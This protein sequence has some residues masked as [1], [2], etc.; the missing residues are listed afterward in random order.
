MSTDVTVNTE[1]PNN[2][3]MESNFNDN[4][5]EVMSTGDT[6][7]SALED[8]L[9]YIFITEKAIN[10]YKNQIYLSYVTTEK[11]SMKI[12]HKKIQNYIQLKRDKNNLLDIMRRFIL[13]RGLICI[14]CEDSSLFIEFQNLYVKYFSNN[15]NLRIV[16]SNIKLQDILDKNEI[17]TLIKE[18][19]MTKNHRGINEV[20]IEI[21]KKYF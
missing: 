19:H 8:S 20:Y 10:L 9:D 17:I 18:E 1:I 3:A 12:V 13:D 6:V 2:D 11:I 16:K 7:H 14:Y 15:N 4:D 21:K 5:D